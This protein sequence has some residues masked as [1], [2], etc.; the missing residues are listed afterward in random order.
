M[1][2]ASLWDLYCGV[3]GFAHHS[4][5][6]H[7]DVPRDVVGIEVSEQS[8]P[9]ATSTPSTDLA[10][11][12]SIATRQARLFD[13]FPQTDLHEVMLLLERSA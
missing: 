12:P 5:G 8:A 11:R 1:A 7:D 9:A 13:M 3:G 6:Q 10:R 4:A 2:P